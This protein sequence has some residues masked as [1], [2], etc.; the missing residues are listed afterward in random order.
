VQAEITVVV[1]AHNEGAHLVETIRR[2][3]WTLPDDAEIVIVDD[4]S[5]DGSTNVVFRDRRV[6]LLRLR[7]VGV[8]AARNAGASYAKGD[9][10]VFLDGHVWVDPGWWRPLVELL[11]NLTIGAVSPAVAPVG[12]GRRGFGLMFDGPELRV[13]WLERRGSTPYAVPLLPGCSVAVRRQT[14]VATG[15]FD[16]GMIRWGSI[17]NEFSLRLW[18]LGYELWIAPSVEVVHLFRQS[19]P[20]R[21]EWLWVVHNV[22]RLALVHFGPRRVERVMAALREYPDFAAALALA[23]AKGLRSRRS[24]LAAA[25]L[26]SDDTFFARFGSVV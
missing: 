20:Y 13:T 19:H 3:L 2:L 9:V 26:V 11:G 16:T 6:R 8:A 23:R 14:F 17:D 21:V 18:L 22:L 5:S 24:E 4:A 12:G 1:I 10:L 7:G 15:G 25:R